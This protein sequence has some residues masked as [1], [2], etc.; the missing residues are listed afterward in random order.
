MM[1]TATVRYSSADRTTHQEI[2]AR[3][4]SLPFAAAWNDAFLGSGRLKL[5]NEG[6]IRV[7]IQR[8]IDALL[9]ARLSSTAQISI[10]G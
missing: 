10:G 3:S 7:S 8:L 2:I 5:A 1:V 4:V 6:A 9:P